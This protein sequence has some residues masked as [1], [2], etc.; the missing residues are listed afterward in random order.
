MVTKILQGT[1]SSKVSN[2]WRWEIWLKLIEFWL[3]THKTTNLQYIRREGNKVADL[4]EN[5]GVE[6]GKDLHTDNLS[7][8]AIDQQ[9]LE[10]KD[11]VKREMTQEEE[12]HPDAGVSQEH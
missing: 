7:M 9:I 12:A 3:S 5:I 4:L 6:S 2:S 1:P 10:Y 11:L 8:L